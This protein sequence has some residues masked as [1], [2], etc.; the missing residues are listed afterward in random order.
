MAH[1]IDATINDT[2]STADGFVIT[3]QCDIVIEGLTSG[4]V[5]FQYKLPP[6]PG[7]AAGHANVWTDFPEGEFTADTYKTVFISEHGVTGR[8]YGNGCNDGVYVR[9]ARY[10]NV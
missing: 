10:N 8:L 7:S 5:K 9:L 4:S 6:V 3:G 2:E 1:A